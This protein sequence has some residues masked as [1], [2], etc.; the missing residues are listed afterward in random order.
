MCIRDSPTVDP[1]VI[2]FGDAALIIKTE[3]FLKRITGYANNNGHQ[4]ECRLVDYVPTDFV[5][6][7]GLFTKTEPF[8]YQSE[9]RLVTYDGPGEPITL[10]LGNLST[11]SERIDSSELPAL[12]DDL[13]TRNKKQ[14]QD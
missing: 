13:R 1:R 14:A 8:E 12:V 11:I 2:E 3:D 4:F 10:Q 5:G 7:T 9:W 6:D